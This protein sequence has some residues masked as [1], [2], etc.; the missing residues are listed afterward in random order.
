MHADYKPW[1]L[2]VCRPS[3]SG[4]PD[5]AGAGR[6]A[7]VLDWEFAFVGP[8]LVGVAIFLRHRAALPP[9]YTR[10]FLV[11][12]EA[13]GGH[14]PH[15]WPAQTKLLDLLNLCSMLEQP[16]GGST[17]TRDIRRLILAT[18]DGWPTT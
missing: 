2:L 18:V 7:G 1:N 12:Y 17:R 4:A 3:A 9:E 16:G 8:P 5:A 14:L 10:G 15:D 6:V 11:G 13:G